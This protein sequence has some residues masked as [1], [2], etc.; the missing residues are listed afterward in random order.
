MPMCITEAGRYGIH[1]MELLINKM[2]KLGAKRENLRAKA[3]GG[4]S[5]LPSAN[6]TDNFLCVG[7]VNCRFIVEFLKND[8]IPLVTSDLGGDRGMFI[9]FSSKDHSVLRRKIA[10]SRT[11]D[12]QQNEK[13]FW[14]TSIKTEEQISTEPD[15]WL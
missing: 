8:G 1:D 11:P 9:R 6:R 10:K 5:L 12:L 7:E 4:S 13:Q 2:L 15:I 14:M 3:F